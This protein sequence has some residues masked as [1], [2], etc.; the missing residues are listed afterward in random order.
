ME[1]P[2]MLTVEPGKWPSGT[3]YGEMPIIWNRDGKGGKSA[4]FPQSHQFDILRGR[5]SSGAYF[6]L[7]NGEISYWFDTQ[8]RAVGTFAVMSRDEF[9]L[10]EHRKYSSIEFQ[11]EGLEAI[12]D[13]APIAAT[14]HPTDMTVEQQ[15]AATLNKDAKLDWTS[16][17]HK[18]SFWYNGSFRSF[19]AY[20]F[21]MAFSPVLRLTSTIPLSSGD[22]WINWI[23]PLRQLISLATNAPRAVTYFCAINGDDLARSSRDQI[24]GWDISHEP[25]NSTTAAIRDIKPSIRLKSDGVDLLD[26]L[27]RWQELTEARHPMI[28]TYGAMVTV[29]EQ[30][31][32]SRF[33]LLLQAIEGLHGFE[34]KVQREDRQQKHS[35]E[36]EAYIE[37]VGGSLA[38]KDLKFLKKNLMKYPIEG[39]DTALATTFKSLPID[40]QPEL[41][42]SK[43][44][45]QIRD[46]LADEK[47]NVT[48]ALR[49]T[50]NDLSHGSSNFDPQDL[51][52]VA[53]ILDRV[54]RSEVLRVLGAPE[55]ARKRSLEHPK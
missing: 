47:L 23:K 31:P 11:I 18:M 26:L 8:G 12:A 49:R 30:H 50:R 7:M 46:E 38:A 39:L 54:V 36:R 4:G 48:T 21:Q 13:V 35:S 6:A 44:V 34:H 9:V 45:Q 16:G 1:L 43:L 2:G 42:K 24:F 32:R 25:A 29:A 17:D 10:E 27:I 41:E 37:R 53:L 33:L 5:L 14:Q 52:E 28:E 55:S 51:H 22:W 3:V 20:E 19:D 40:I 15:W